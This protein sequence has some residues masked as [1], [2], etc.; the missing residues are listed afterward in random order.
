MKPR[1][2]CNCHTC[3]LTRVLERLARKGTKAERAAVEELLLEWEAAST[4][5]TY[6]RMKYQRTWPG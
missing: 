4:S 5:A 3:K 1:K 2:P 6:W